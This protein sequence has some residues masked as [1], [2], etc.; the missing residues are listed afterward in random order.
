MGSHKEKEAYLTKI[1]C[2]FRVSKVSEAALIKIE[3]P[4]QMYVVSII[5]TNFAHN[6]ACV[7]VHK[8]HCN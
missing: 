3:L 8:V 1:N 7:R 2:N 5:L 6:L 4:S